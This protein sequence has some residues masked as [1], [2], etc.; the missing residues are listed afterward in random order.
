MSAFGVA[1]GVRAES[2]SGNNK[3]RIA[4]VGDSISD[5]YW[6]GV[7]V[8]AARD[9]CLKALTEFGRFAKNSTGLTRPDRFDWAAE[10]KRVGESFKPRL[11]VMSLGLNDRQ[12][13]VEHGQ[14][15][16]DDSPLYDDKYKERITAVLKNAAAA[17]AGLLWIGLP[18]LRVPSS[19]K[20]AREKNRLFEEAIT[21]FG[22][23]DIQ[24]I[25]PWKLNQTGVDTFSSYGPD[26]NGRMVQLRTPDGEHFT[27]AG[28][29]LAAA[30]LLPRIVASVAH[31]GVSA[32][33]RSE[34]RS[35][36]LQPKD[37]QLNE[38]QPTDQQLKDQQLREPK[39]QEPQGRS[40]G[41]SQDEA[42]S[43]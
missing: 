13:V 11:F 4:F 1:R 15:T 25:P 24:Y 14:I 31:E 8:T 37:Q 17:K 2:D 40:Q 18:A 36:D 20:D 42:Q 28:E 19:D 22:A 9:P 33:T 6:E 27:V 21:A 23:P 3:V 43:Q 29:M 7:S 12:S 38:P 34:A 30:Y 26:A 32:C 16:M 41:Q 35:Q 39:D 5:G 10:L